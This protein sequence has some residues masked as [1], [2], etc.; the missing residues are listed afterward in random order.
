M[1]CGVSRIVANAHAVGSGCLYFPDVFLEFRPQNVLSSS[2]SSSSSLSKNRALTRACELGILIFSRALGCFC[3]TS[4]QASRRSGAV[5]LWVGDS[6]ASVNMPKSCQ[7]LR[8]LQC[9]TFDLCHRDH[10]FVEKVKEY[11][12]TERKHTRRHQTTVHN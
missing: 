9:H 5:H 2:S 1:P 11:K 6:R 10:L 8:E 3:A 7:L 4:V 12:A